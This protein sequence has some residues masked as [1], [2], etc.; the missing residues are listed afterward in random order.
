M[1][2]VKTHFPTSYITGNTV[3]NKWKYLKENFC[4]E[5]NKM[6][7]N[8]FGDRGLSPAKANVSGGDLVFFKVPR[9]LETENNM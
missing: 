6:N 9:M 8:K 7:A 5:L 2:S 1:H 3:T 4:A